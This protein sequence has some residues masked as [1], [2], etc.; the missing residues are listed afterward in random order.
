MFAL[1][2]SAFLAMGSI[3]MSEFVF[4][5]DV[6]DVSGYIEAVEKAA[7]EA[8]YEPSD[9]EVGADEPSGDVIAEG[10]TSQTDILEDAA[11]GSE[12][13][14]DG[15]EAAP[16]NAVESSG[17]TVII[18]NFDNIEVMNDS[19]TAISE[20]LNTVVT[21][22]ETSVDSYQVSEYFVNYF[23]G[24]LQNMPYTEYL[25]YAERVQTSNTGYNNY[26]THYYLM[27]DLE[28]EDGQVVDGEY[29]CIDVYS[30]NSIYYL[31]E[32]TKEFEGY[33]TMGFASF[34]PYSALI[35]RSFH[36]NDFFVGVL[37]VLV[38]FIL[39]RK[40]VFT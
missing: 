34:A 36:Y 14:G 23:R 6:I 21:A 13:S 9:K 30:S 3:D 12:G 37:C 39:C 1:I 26:I 31:E 29:P 17:D 10:E 7:S 27:Y 22:L 11:G 8:Q 40:T 2:L 24:V 4:D 25:C 35:D 28:L 16:G 33:P 32:T 20:D 5:D 38:F 15:G 19:L 18:Y